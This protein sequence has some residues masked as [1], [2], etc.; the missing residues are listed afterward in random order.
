[1]INTES[2]QVVASS[3]A[4]VSISSLYFRDLSSRDVTACKK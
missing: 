4:S 1:M 3:H 2:M